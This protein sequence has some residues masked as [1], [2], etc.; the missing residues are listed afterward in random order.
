MVFPHGGPVPRHPSQLYEAGLE[1]LVLFII[2]FLVATRTRALQYRGIGGGLFLAGYGVS[3][4]IIECFREPDVQVGTFAY[5]LSMGQLLCMPMVAVGLW[6][7]L[8]AK[9]RPVGLL[10]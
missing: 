5:G 10:P 3:R 2:L 1:G 6:L 7:M 8:S 9:R 4:F